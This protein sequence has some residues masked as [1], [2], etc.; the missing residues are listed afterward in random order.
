MEL[1]S[2]TGDRKQTYRGIQNTSGGDKCQV[3]KMQCK[4][5][6]EEVAWEGCSVHGVGRQACCAPLYHVHLAHITGP[7]ATPRTSRTFQPH[8][9]SA[10]LDGDLEVCSLLF[11]LP[12]ELCLRL[13]AKKASMPDALRQ[14]CVYSS[15]TAKRPWCERGVWR[16]RGRGE[17]GWLV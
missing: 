13:T 8:V 10:H 7:P 14:E 12:P 6:Q 11:P 1:C 15:R 9:C 3:E 2:G 4:K 16:D 17:R 5:P